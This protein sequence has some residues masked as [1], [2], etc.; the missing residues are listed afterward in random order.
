MFDTEPLYR[1]LLRATGRGL[2]SLW[3]DFLEDLGLCRRLKHWLLTAPTGRPGAHHPPDCVSTSGVVAWDRFGRWAPYLGDLAHWGPGRLGGWKWQRGEYVHAVAAIEGI[4]GVDWVETTTVEHWHGEIQQINGVA[5]SKS[6]LGE[7]TSFDDF[8]YRRAAWCLDPVTP[9]RL[10]AV[11]EHPELRILRAFGDQ[12]TDHF[13]A[14]SWH[15][16]L[17]LCNAGGSHHFAAAR[18]LGR[19]LD[20]PVPLEGR[21]VYHQLRTREVAKFLEHYACFA[22][23]GLSGDHA[24]MRTALEGFRV[25]YYETYLPPPFQTDLLVIVFP[26]SC[27]RSADA[28]ALFK[29]AGLFDVGD[30]L[31]IACEH[32]AA[33]QEAWFLQHGGRISEEKRSVPLGTAFQATTAS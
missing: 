26:Y 27:A 15:D 18:W 3:D 2:I 7:F 9:E 20:I 12:G 29:Q 8:A 1:R 23:P 19:R 13:E 28:A 32:S 10:A 25:E 22:I 31:R 17:F 21:L 24:R 11:L 4:A 30:E 14:F 6:R 33:S 16:R 5:A